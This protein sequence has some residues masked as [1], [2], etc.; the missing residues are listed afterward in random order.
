[1]ADWAV[2]N[3]VNDASVEDGR[4]TYKLLP[5]AAATSPIRSGEVITTVHQFG[6]DYLGVLEGPLKLQFDGEETVGLT[7]ARPKQGRSMWWSNRGDDSVASMT[8]AFD[9]SGVQKA[10]LQF[11]TWY[12]IEQD[13][14]YGY[15]AVS[16]DDGKNW[17]TLKGDT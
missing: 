1:F 8:R 10:T 6:A 16:T 3:V 13:F 11:S 5:G 2:A 12:E 14:D 15:A 7:G 4:Y 17:T 9:L